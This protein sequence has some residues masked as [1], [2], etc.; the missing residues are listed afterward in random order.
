MQN[1]KKEKKYNTVPIISILLS[2]FLLMIPWIFYK[3]QLNITVEEKTIVPASITGVTDY[4]LYGK[5]CL[6]IITALF[7]LFLFLFDL[8]TKKSVANLFKNDNNKKLKMI[9]ILAIGYAM[10]AILSTLFSKY[11]TTS[12]F[13]N[14]N[15]CEGVFVLCSYM[16]IFMA[17]CIAFSK[18][19]S[20]HLFKTVILFLTIITIILTAVDFFYLPISQILFSGNWSTDYINMVSLTFYN[21][22]YFGGF[23]ILIF[24]LVCNYFITEDKSKNILIWGILSALMVFCT[25]SSK[26]TSALYC[27]I[28]EIMIS[29]FLFFIHK[30]GKKVFQIAVILGGIVFLLLINLLSGNKLLNILTSSAVNETTAIK[31]SNTY[32][33]NEILVN[34]NILTLQGENTKF[35]VEISN[36]DT[37]EPVIKFYD[38]R[39]HLLDPAVMDNRLYFQGDYEAISAYFENNALTLDLGYK[40]P[41]HFYIKDYRFYPMLSDQTI[42]TNI[43]GNGLGL[44]KYYS[45]ATGRGFIWINSLPILKK[46]VFIGYGPGTFEFRFK[47]YDFAGLLNSQGTT[48]LIVDKPH[49]FYLQIAAQ[50]GMISMLSLIIMFVIIICYSIR[51]YKK[52]KNNGDDSLKINTLVGLTLGN[53]S[54][55]IFLLTND[56]SLTVSPVFWTLLGINA[57]IALYQE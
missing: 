17:A 49:N 37:N 8:I 57:C 38:D 10:L 12:L 20:I 44:D 16:V 42:V 9:F 53:F 1:R 40:E 15:S 11:K 18:G 56:S 21:P 26:S 54:Y 41:V 27:L 5:G 33:V 55:M 22:G 30:S 25:I 48:N 7:I 35:I 19:K 3:I 36:N 46:T 47:Q 4:F 2:I 51:Y 43:S 45:F 6:T 50:T 28:F 13:G 34:D 23:C 14:M 31:S 52:H 32:R 39:Q 29:A 24:P